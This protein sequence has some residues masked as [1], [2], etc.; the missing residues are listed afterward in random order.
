MSEAQ[1]VSFG[2]R[3]LRL[4]NLDKELYPDGFTKAE[5]IS[6]YA[7]IAEALLPHVRDRPVS[8]FRWPNGTGAKSFVHKNVAADAP[9]WLRTE[10]VHGK[11]S[12]A[13]T[14][15]VLDEPAALVWA[16]N[17]AGLELHVPQWRFAGAGSAEHPAEALPPDLMVFDLDPGAPADVVDCCAVALR[18]R[19]L[20]AEDGLTAW[21]KTSG[22]KGLH[23]LVPVQTTD[24]ATTSAYAK[25]LAQDLTAELP[26]TVLWRM[27]RDARPGK[28]F[29]DWSQNNPA[30][31]TVAPY[32]LR[33][34]PSPTVST[35]LTWDEV[36]ACEKPEQLVFTAPD[37]LARVADL[38]DL[39]ADL[40][41]SAQ[42]L[43]ERAKRP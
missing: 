38:G 17:L 28:V 19:D 35:P 25:Q 14:Y 27:A 4:S 37:V 24:S 5:V 22:S 31:T 30:K 15:A 11:G 1:S 23:L 2:G 29:L 21:P 43:P 6:Y 36:A 8:L 34:R 9:D 26:D 16:A 39:L 32:S 42:P 20:L 41:S 40:E 3:T 10:E 13:V 12:D 7:G 33:G 18:V